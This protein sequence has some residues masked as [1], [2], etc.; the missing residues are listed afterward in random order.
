ML[1]RV[2]P[3]RAAASSVV[4]QEA[5]MASQGGSNAFSK[6]LWLFPFFFLLEIQGVKR[7]THNNPAHPTIRA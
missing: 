4:K 5:V 1:F 7:Y 3:P 6:D 2:L